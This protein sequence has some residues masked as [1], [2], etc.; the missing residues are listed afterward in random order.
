MTFPKI[1][2]GKSCHIFLVI[3]VNY[4]WRRHFLTKA[5]LVKLKILCILM[6]WSKWFIFWNT[7]LY[8][9]III[10][11]LELFSATCFLCILHA[12]LTR[13]TAS[14]PK[15]LKHINI[16][17]IPKKRQHMTFMMT[18]SSDHKSNICQV[19]YQDLL[20]IIST[21]YVQNFI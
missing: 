21:V 1:L 3:L 6:Q 20:H 4:C 9:K 8:C 16:S 13:R 11:F 2:L 7:F 19:C 10:S 15:K 12:Q 14:I 18:S 5:I 17:H